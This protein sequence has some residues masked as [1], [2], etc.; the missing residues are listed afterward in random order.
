MQIHPKK[1][2]MM[3][4]SN[5]LP[6]N[7]LCPREDKLHQVY[8]QM[9]VGQ[10]KHGMLT[11]NQSLFALYLRRLITLDEALARSSDIDELKQMIA[12]QQGGSARDV[13]TIS[14]PPRLSRRP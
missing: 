6:K 8:T 10:E 12:L 13:G 1:K 2:K 9:Q 4:N 7:L 11:L 5:H 14:S 3:M